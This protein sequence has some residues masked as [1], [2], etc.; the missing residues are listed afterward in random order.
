[1]LSLLH[2]AEGPY[3]LFSKLIFSYIYM[4]R[5]YIYI[6]L[7]C[8]FS[9]FLSIGDGQ[10][11]AF[12]FEDCI[13]KGCGLRGTSPWQHIFC[14]RVVGLRCSPILSEPTQPHPCSVPSFY[15]CPLYTITPDCAPD[16]LNPSNPKLQQSGL[17]IWVFRDRTTAS[18]HTSTVLVYISREHPP[19]GITFARAKT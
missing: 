6:R 15:A 2:Q 11:T 10:K 16:W 17:C 8:I 1:M 9:F 4:L 14:E 3:C 5:L 12:E 19:N 18:P 13:V 7:L